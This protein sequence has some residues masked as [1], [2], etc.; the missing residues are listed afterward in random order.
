MSELVEPLPWAEIDTVLLDMD[1][2]L[3]D[4]RFDNWFWQEHLPARYAL[5]RGM[6]PAAAIAH[7]TPR[8][9]AARGRLEWYCIDHW[10]RELELDVRAIKHGVREQ[11]AW[12]PGAEGFLARLAR[13]GKRRV[14]ITN[15]HPEALAI[16]D[17]HV[18][19]IAHLDEAHSSHP[20]GVPKEDPAFWA[21]FR[22]ASPFDPGRTLFVDDSL[23]VLASA[24]EF[25]I[26]WLRAIRRPD[27]GRPARD[28]GAFAGVDSVADLL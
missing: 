23:P 9:E 15:A 27:S 22:A 25:G 17:S 8:F 21:R 1:G 12:I 10:S 6:S 4:L 3:L 5:E 28:T 14:L 7:L 11:V 18:A 2:T 20:F 24:R 16:K 13:L 19:L 26:R